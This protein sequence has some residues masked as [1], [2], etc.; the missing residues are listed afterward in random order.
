MEGDWRGAY[1]TQH[2][3]RL[4]FL[5]V[6][7]VPMLSNRCIDIDRNMVRHRIEHNKDDHDAEQRQKVDP[8]Q[9]LGGFVARS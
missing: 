6:C 8:E 5:E 9:Q 7:I 4:L 2:G 3:G 1:I